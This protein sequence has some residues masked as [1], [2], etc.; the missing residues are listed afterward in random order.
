MT[1]ASE[2]FATSERSVEPPDFGFGADEA[3]LR[4]Q[5]RKLLVE[6]ASTAALRKLVGADPEAVYRRGELPAYDE[7]AW[8][9]CIELGWTS[10]AVPE[11]CGGIGAKA[12]GV[13]ALVEEVGRHAF[14][15]P[16]LATLA[17]TYVL[18]SAA[19][20]EAKRWLSAIAEGTTMS[21]ALSGEL[22]FWELD[23]TDVI[24][25]QRGSKIVL[26]GGAFFVQDASKVDAFL[27]AARAPRGIC[28]VALR[29]NTPGLSIER[30]HI[31]DLTRDQGHLALDGVEV[32]EADLIAPPPAGHEVL[33]R[34]W[35]AVL[36]LASADLVGVSE[37]L[38]QTTVAY[39]KVRKQFDRTIGFF[40]AV[41]HPLVNAMIDIDLARSLLYRAA[42]TLDV[43]THRAEVPARMAKS[44]ASDAAAFVA[45]R[46][47]QLHGGIGFTWECDVHFYFKRARHGQTLY[48]DGVHQREKLARLLIDKVD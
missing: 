25:E 29:K 13:A 22:G 16:L 35:P 15:S 33:Q 44:A 23:Q 21:L 48:G 9:R 6:C 2:T 36:M 47:V 37:W 8:K 14:P 40:Q 34:A 17:S 42:C 5:A 32:R 45:G 31:L 38:L 11:E 46:A 30:D 1:Q 28:L 24:A 18:R 41:K 7:Q 4:E 43:D 3:L 20:P 39:A 26:S 10:L 12:V 27:V 19:S